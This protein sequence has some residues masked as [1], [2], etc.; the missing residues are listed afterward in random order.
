MPKSNILKVNFWLLAFSLNRYPPV[1]RSS[2]IVEPVAWV[3]HEPGLSKI[4]KIINLSPILFSG[5][6]MVTLPGKYHQPRADLYSE[7]D[8]FD[9]NLHVNSHF[10]EAHRLRWK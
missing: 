8:D 7:S 1:G 6:F 10:M 3:M 5:Y 4:Y 9:L 2:F